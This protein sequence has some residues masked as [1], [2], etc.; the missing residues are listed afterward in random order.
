MTFMDMN[1]IMCYKDFENPCAITQLLSFPVSI[2]IT[3]IPLQFILRAISK[4]QAKHMSLV[5]LNYILLSYH[6]H[7]YTRIRS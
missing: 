6:P 5:P 2:D 4:L 1:K 7:Q 3:Q